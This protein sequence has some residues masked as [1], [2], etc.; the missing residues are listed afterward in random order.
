MLKSVYRN[1]AKR[2]GVKA[3][4]AGIIYEMPFHFPSYYRP[5]NGSIR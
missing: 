2:A 5:A 4:L 3:D 1:L